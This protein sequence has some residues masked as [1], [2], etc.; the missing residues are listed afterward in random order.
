MYQYDS[1]IQVMTTRA[2]RVI[3]LHENNTFVAKF[4]N[5][6]IFTSTEENASTRISVECPGYATVTYF[7][8]QTKCAIKYR[9]GF[10]I[11]CDDC[12]NYNTDESTLNLSLLSRGQALYS[13]VSGGKYYFDYSG[14]DVIL[15]AIDSSSHPI[16][17]NSRGEVGTS[18]SIH[19]SQ[20]VD[21]H[22]AFKPKIFIINPDG[23]GY[24]L[25]ESAK[26]Q[27]MIKVAECEG[28]N[29]VV[30]DIVI[31]GTRCISALV[32]DHIGSCMN[33]VEDAKVT[34]TCLPAS[35][36][37]PAQDMHLEQG[38][39]TVSDNQGILKNSTES[40]ALFP[41]KCF[42]TFD[43]V[44]DDVRDVLQSAACSTVRPLSHSGCKYLQELWQNTIR[45]TSSILIDRVSK[46]M[47][48]ATSQMKM[49]IVKKT[50]MSTQG[51]VNLKKILNAARR[52]FIP[53][54]FDNISQAQKS[55][56]DQSSGSTRNVQVVVLNPAS[57]TVHNSTT[58][59]SD[60]C[61]N[62]LKMKHDTD[63][64]LNPPN[65]NGIHLKDNQEIQVYRPYSRVIRRVSLISD[66]RLIMNVIGSKSIC[67]YK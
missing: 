6:T 67:V 19:C 35:L 54:Y 42:L 44:S 18:D 32:V 28:R 40:N 11:E 52:R 56:H 47:S 10:Q 46:N 7:A 22:E 36:S 31:P 24:E 16:K 8:N 21:S 4:P 45:T 5:G 62:V 50:S 27:E 26:T 37:V 57:Q 1:F 53:A 48:N 65:T 66:M 9:D 2:D 15:D 43:P 34:N 41:F 25:L 12:G 64:L 13:P 49:S 60:V 33:K 23:N 63:I 14:S 39:L 30:K 3:L 38:W 29:A 20:H 17:V 55:G 58:E 61:R 59:S 51:D